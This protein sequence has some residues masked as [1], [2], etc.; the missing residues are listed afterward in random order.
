MTLV[1]LPA[2]AD[3]YIWMLQ[4]ESGAIVVDPGDAK[5]VLNALAQSHVNLA[6]I[7]V[8]HHHADHVGGVDELRQATGAAVFGPA[9]EVIPE[10]CT[11]LSEGDVAEVLGLPF[12]VIDVPGHT[13]GHIAYFL[14]AKASPDGVPLLFCGDTLFS[15]GCGRLF[16]GSP[17]QMLHSLDALAALPADT[18]VCC[19]HEYTLS[20]LRFARAV[21]PSNDALAQYMTSCEARR[22]AGE[23]TLP[24]RIDTE[25]SINPFLRSREASVRRAVSTHAGLAAKADDADVFAALRQWKNDFR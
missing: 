3:N 1:P 24:S 11:P 16:E 2:F 19:A 8:T 7:L 13:A 9:G 23:P 5:P 20:N 25:R 6:A 14:P 21:E 12:S 17:R 4:I 10:P 18:R 22:A 15:G